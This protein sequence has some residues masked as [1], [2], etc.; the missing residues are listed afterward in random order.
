MIFKRAGYQKKSFLALLTDKQKEVLS[1]AYKYGYYDLPKRINSE[2]LA[3]RVNLSKPTMIEHLR[4]AE[5]RV[6]EEII[7][8]YSV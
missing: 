8:G 5:R 3:E 7:E 1:A 6:L 2:R 4:K